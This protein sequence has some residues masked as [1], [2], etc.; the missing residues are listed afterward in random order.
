MR[1]FCWASFCLAALCIPL[2]GCESEVAPGDDL[3]EVIY[4][5]PNVPARINLIQCRNSAR[6]RNRPTTTPQTTLLLRGDNHERQTLDRQPAPARFQLRPAPAGGPGQRPLFLAY[7]LGDTGLGYGGWGYGCCYG[8][9]LPSPAPYFAVHPPVYYSYP[10]ATPYGYSPFPNPPGVVMC[11][12]AAADA[13]TSQTT[14]SSP[15]RIANP[16]VPQTD[17]TAAVPAGIRP[18]PKV[19]YPAAIAVK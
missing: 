14:H 18:L 17:A 3:G 4:W 7:G 16:F 19:V 10:V 1:L 8:P 12:G 2:A 15:L 11:Q 5:V 13:Q 6:T 9:N